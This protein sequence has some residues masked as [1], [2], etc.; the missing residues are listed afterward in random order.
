VAPE[1]DAQQ[2]FAWDGAPAPDADPAAGGPQPSAPPRARRGLP[3]GLIAAGAL[4]VAAV[5]ALAISLSVGGG[6]SAGGPVVLAADVTA[7]EPGFKLALTISGRV[8]G[9]SFST[10][11]SGAFNAGPPVSGSFDVTIG[12]VSAHEL[13]TGGDYYLQL[14]TAPGRWF[15]INAAKLLAASGESPSTLS[16]SS[17]DPTQTLEM[18]R[19]AGTVTDEGPD[20]IAGVATTHYHALI[21][22]D[23]YAA[24][25][26]SDEQAAAQQNAHH[27]EQLTGSSSLP[28]DVWI[29]D[30]NLVR[31]LQLD[32]GISTKL[33]ELS[34]AT[35]I[36][37]SDYGPQPAVSAPPAGEVTDISSLVDANVA[38]STQNLGLGSSPS[39]PAPAPGN[40]GAAG[41]S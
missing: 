10:Q 14:P 27:L 29:D 11:G 35:T 20:T 3:K 4:A 39:T 37:I 26:P 18:L 19:A 31:Q 6:S 38:Q 40:T 15:E 36:E 7:R 24:L 9:Q 22:L 34:E 1:A 13:F 33:G 5:V 41:A 25:L 16:L 23:R 30:S 2:P 28:L 21:D 32:L 12:S 8:A 17:G